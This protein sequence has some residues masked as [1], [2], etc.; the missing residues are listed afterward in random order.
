M[1]LCQYPCQDRIRRFTL[2]AIQIPI[3]YN[4]YGDYDP[5]GLLY[6]LEHA[7]RRNTPGMLIRKAFSFSMIWRI[8]GAV[9]KPPTSMDFLG[10]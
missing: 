4:R 3:V 2:E 9:K 1:E 6:V 7:V 8:P 10:P 5:G